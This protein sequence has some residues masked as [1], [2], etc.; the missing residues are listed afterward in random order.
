M[1]NPPD[2]A[3]APGGVLLTEPPV[4]P[5]LFAVVGASAAILVANL[6]YAQPLIT[7]IAGALGLKPEF[8]GSVV[9]ASQL[10]YGLGLFLLVPLA[11]IFENKRLVL[12]C[13]LLALIGIIG[14]ATA[15][16]ATTFLVF[17]TLTGIFSS[18]AQMLIPYLSHLIPTGQRGRILGYVMA[19]ILTS[20]MLARPFALFVA[21]TFGWRIVYVL[22]AAATACLGMAL[23][24]MM[25]PR[26]PQG[27]IPYRQAIMSMF[28]LFSS[29]PRVQRRTIYQ[30]ILFAVFTMFWAVI[31]IV[32]ADHFALGKTAIGLFALAGAGGA[33]AAPM[34]GRFADRGSTRIGSAAAS[35]LIAGSFLLSLWSL[36]AGILIAL[37][38]AAVFIDG[39]V[40]AVQAFSRLVVLD[41]DPKIRGRINALYMTIIY[42]SGALGS[43]IGVSTYFTWGWPAV[44]TLGTAAGLAV[45]LGVLMEKHRP[46]V[47]PDV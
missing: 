1:K 35:L 32:L 47:S 5:A 46:L 6:Y 20:V 16:S 18:G 10:G 37:V 42:I 45:F 24:R 11:D 8:A 29:E 27:R 26:H 15:R 21:A 4:S 43:V 33:L 38:V 7:T 22:S 31:P 44:A 28:A 23:W 17:A 3:G 9:S 34:A 30:A 13:G 39:S 25:P 36:Y 2:D 19:G 41:V 14:I 12:S 40:Q